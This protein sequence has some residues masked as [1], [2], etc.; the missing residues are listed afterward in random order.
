LASFRSHFFSFFF[1]H[2]HKTEADSVSYVLTDSESE[3]NISVTSQ[4]FG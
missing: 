3:V 2:Y 4:L 1:L